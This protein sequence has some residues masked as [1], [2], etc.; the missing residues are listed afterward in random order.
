MHLTRFKPPCFPYVF[1]APFVV[2]GMARSP[3]AG[4]KS[5]NEL[6]DSCEQPRTRLFDLT[7]T[8]DSSAP[9]GVNRNMFLVNGQFP[10]PKMEL[11][12]GDSVIVNLK[13]SSPFNTSIHYHGTYTEQIDH[14][15]KE[16]HFT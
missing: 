11:N 9:D 12:E 2:L 1:L 15:D 4:G 14:K 10:G 13:N 6:F 8:W 3:L 16:I 5:S 7:L